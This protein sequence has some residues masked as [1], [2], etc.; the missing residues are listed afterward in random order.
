MHQKISKKFFAYLKNFYINCFV[1]LD[2][3]HKRDLAYCLD[4]QRKACKN[5]GNTY[6]RA[7]NRRGYDTAYQNEHK[8]Y[9]SREKSS[10]KL[11]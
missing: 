3:L 4:K 9:D 2:L 8:T 11:K 10:H 5:Q 6:Y 7:D 1:F